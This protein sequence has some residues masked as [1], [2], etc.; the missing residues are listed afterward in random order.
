MRRQRI[1]LVAITAVAT[2]IITATP[3]H[4]GDDRI[5]QPGLFQGNQP[6]RRDIIAA[7][8]GVDL[9]LDGA[10]PQSG[11]VEGNHRSV[12]KGLRKAGLTHQHKACAKPKSAAAPHPHTPLKT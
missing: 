9:G 6:R 7:R 8:H 11:L 12:V 1:A 2:H 5:A 10:R 4:G 3:H